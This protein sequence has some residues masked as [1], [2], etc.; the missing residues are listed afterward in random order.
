MA[1]LS[2]GRMAAKGGAI[3]ARNVFGRVAFDLNHK[4]RALGGYGCAN[5]GL[6]EM[7]DGKKRVIGG[8]AMRH[9]R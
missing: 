2:C 9:S 3:K 4:H 1:P 5:V 7:L 8:W 6:Q